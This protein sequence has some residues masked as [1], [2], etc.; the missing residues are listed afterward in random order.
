[1]E[2]LALM[3]GVGLPHEAIREQLGRGLDLVIHLARL[4]DGSRKVVEVAEVV[5]AAGSVG[6]RSLFRLGSKIEVRQWAQPA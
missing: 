3:A 4:S 2:T 6:V 5:R 1:V